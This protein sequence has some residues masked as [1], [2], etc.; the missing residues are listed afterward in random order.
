MNMRFLTRMPILLL[1]LIT[2][3]QPQEIA[4]APPRISI[5]A[6]PEPTSNPPSAQAPAFPGA[7]GFGAKSTGG[8]KGKIIEV[9][10]L[11][12]TG[13]GSLRAAI[14]DTGPRIIIFRVGGT[15]E[16]KSSL[17]I[18]EPYITIAGQTAPGD[19]ITLKDD[20]TNSE[21]PLIVNTHDV[22]IQYI[23]SRPGPPADKSENGDAI[24]ILG[25][26]AYNVI[27]DHCSFSWAIDEVASIW[28]D[29]RDITIQ[30]SII[31]EGLHCS[32]HIKGCH[33]MG[34]I[35]GST[36][37]K[38]ITIHHNLFAHNHERNP[39]VETSGLVDV[40]NNVI[41]NSWGSPALVSDEYGDVKANFVANFMKFGPD[42]DP[43]KF[44]VSVQDVRGKGA[45]IFV[46]GNITPNRPSDNLEQTL[47]VKA[48][49]R[50]WMVKERFPAPGISSQVGSQ[51]YDFV[52]AGAGATIGLD[53]LGVEF[54]RRDSVDRRIVEDVK[55]KSG[56]IIDD[57]S[58]VGGWPQL[59]SGIAPIDTDHDGMPD[60]W[61]QQ[62]GLNPLDPSDG[63]ADNDGD[64]YTNVEEYLN[65]TEPVN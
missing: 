39:L 16:L 36:G 32:N 5:P 3:C 57:P 7:E 48:N 41:Y 9:T 24:E 60:R 34:L 44:L 29:A 63:P 52:L 64:G 20:P 59:S 23:R 17:E 46:E 22:I 13:L 12:D 21:G 62:Y 28:Y 26:K 14:E 43:S 40:V 25:G 38:N 56:K 1:L 10:N 47:A 2:G 8:R 55:N 15:I 6:S 30:W 33:S 37:A 18:T 35:I 53:E 49:S 27:I 50:K 65:E 45:G 58:E 54:Y 42:S 51:V 61:E 31:S 4:I 11:N 19:G